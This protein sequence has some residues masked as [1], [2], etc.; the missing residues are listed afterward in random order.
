M[1]ESRYVLIMCLIVLLSGTA[2][3]K[4][5]FTVGEGAPQGEMVYRH[6]HHHWIFGLI[7]DENL[8]IAKICPSGNATIHEE[9]SFLNGLIEVL[10]GGIYTPTTV[11]V[12]C[13]GGEVATVALQEEQILR[14]V[15]DPVFLLLVE[16]RL[17]ERLEEVVIAMEQQERRGEAVLAGR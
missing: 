5:T 10:I 6:W 1:T 8:A 2:C 11:T 15:N 17:P 12:M 13:D 9:T 7:G 4:H 14:I 3:V 16:E